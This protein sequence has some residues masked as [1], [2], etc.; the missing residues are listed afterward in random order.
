LGANLQRRELEMRKVLGFFALFMLTSLPAVAQFSATPKIEVEGGYA[1]RAFQYPPSYGEGTTVDTY[2]RVKMNGFDVNAVYNFT[3][4]I[5]VVGDVDGT[6]NAAP[7]PFS[8]TDIT[9]V[10]SVAGGP[11]FYPVGHHKLTPFAEVLVGHGFL[12]ITAPA[13]SGCGTGCK[14]TDGSFVWS[15]G[16]GV[17]W[18]LSRHFAVRLGEVDYEQTTFQAIASPGL[19][20]VDKNFKYKAGFIVRF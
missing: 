20:D 7:D 19:T 13:V 8:G 2:P 15:A 11:R 4:W 1:F 14:I 10:Y 17:D 9:W 3:S 16:G 6:R 12:S 5:G 18:S